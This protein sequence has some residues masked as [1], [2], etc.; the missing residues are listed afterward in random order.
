MLGNI[1][2]TLKGLAR[3]SRWRGGERE[4]EKKYKK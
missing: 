2:H 3:N 4:R 1:Y